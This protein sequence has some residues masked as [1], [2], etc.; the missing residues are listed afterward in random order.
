MAG[1]S[2]GDHQGVYRLDCRGSGGSAT[3]PP[4]LNRRPREWVAWALSAAAVSEAIARSYRSRRRCQ[5]LSCFQ[6]RHRYGS[7]IIQLGGRGASRSVQVKVLGGLNH[8]KALVAGFSSRTLGQSNYSMSTASI[9]AEKMR[10][11]RCGGLLPGHRHPCAELE[12]GDGRYF[13]GVH[14]LARPKEIEA[15]GH[16]RRCSW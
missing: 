16:R 2:A 10:E 11:A 7:G 5:R 9:T 12:R 8:G 15:A 1:H 13:A 6:T 4:Q 3:R 14:G